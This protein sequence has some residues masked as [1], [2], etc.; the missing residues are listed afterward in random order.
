MLS[1]ID[2]SVSQIE[3]TD[4]QDEKGSRSPVSWGF[5]AGASMLLL[6]AGVLSIANSPAHAFEQFMYMWYW[7]LPLITG[8]SL[9]VGLFVY[10]RNRMLELKSS[11]ASSGAIAASGGMSATAMVA[12]CAHHL[13]D[14]LPVLGLS[15]AAIFVTRFQSV[16]LLL[17]AVSTLLG[18]IYMLKVI[19]SNGLAP[20]GKG[21][22]SSI[23]KLDMRKAFA[24]VAVLGVISLVTSVLMHI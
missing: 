9:Q 2:G 7:V 12:C 18:I 16:F 3:Q 13:T 21:I 14:L 15:V 6:Y 22:L 24:V 23:L 1:N 17:G 8:F 5:I 10:I 11:G 20:E 19:Q 4:N